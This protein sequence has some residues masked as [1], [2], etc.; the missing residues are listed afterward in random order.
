MAQ[1]RPAWTDERLDDLSGQVRDLGRRMDAGFARVDEDLRAL[2]SETHAEVRALRTETSARFDAQDARFDA[3]NRTL[4]RVG[5][6]AIVTLVVGF[7]SVLV[8]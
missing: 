5:G 8:A 6:G 7:A 3:L 4:L 2:R 1:T